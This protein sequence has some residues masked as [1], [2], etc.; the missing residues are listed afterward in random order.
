MIAIRDATS[1]DLPAILA[2]Y[3]DAVVHTTAVYDYVPRTLAAQQEWFAAK[4]AQ[5]W[6]VLVAVEAATVVGFCSYGAFRPWSAYQ[7][8]VENSIYIAP[9]RRGRGIGGQLLP[10]LIERATAGGFHAVIAGIDASNE[11]SLRLHAKLG[12]VKVAHLREVGWKFERWLDLVF[13]E[14]LL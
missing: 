1:D 11:A 13:L 8:T 6:P 7:R 5:R 3:H 4:T 14:R 12:F 9:E 2:I 10:P